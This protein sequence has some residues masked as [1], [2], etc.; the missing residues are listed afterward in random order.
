MLV[1]PIFTSFNTR[2]P[3]IIS[4]LSDFV[5]LCTLTSTLCLLILLGSPHCFFH[6]SLPH[7]FH[8]TFPSSH[9]QSPSP[10][11]STQLFKPKSQNHAQF[12]PFPNTQFLTPSAS[13]YFHCSRPPA[14]LPQLSLTLFPNHLTPNSKSELS[15]WKPGYDNSLD[16]HPEQNPNI[17]PCLQGPVKSTSA[18]SSQEQPLTQP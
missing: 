6:C 2:L 13:L 15:G 12:L 11:P 7:L 10:S 14:G 16:L 8:P 9:P 4:A 5:L 3:C 1:D 18:C 17:V